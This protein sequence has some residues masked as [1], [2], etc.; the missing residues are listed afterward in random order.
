MRQQTLL[1]HTPQVSPLGIYSIP[2]LCFGGIE[3]SSA[4][5]YQPV[6]TMLMVPYLDNAWAPHRSR[7]VRESSIPA[8]AAVS[9]CCSTTYEAHLGQF[10]YQRSPTSLGTKIISKRRSVCHRIMPRL[11]SGETSPMEA[12]LVDHVWSLQELVA[13]LE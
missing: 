1:G 13:L 11:S 12:G 8:V 5:G 3:L 4:T 9:W 10:F 6:T 7:A 2:A